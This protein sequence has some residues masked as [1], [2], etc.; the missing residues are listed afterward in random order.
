MVLELRTIK[1]CENYPCSSSQILLKAVASSVF[2]R[3]EVE[4]FTKTNIG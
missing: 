2:L 1:K 3:D 4:V